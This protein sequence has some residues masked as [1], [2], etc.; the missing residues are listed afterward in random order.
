MRALVANVA[1]SYGNHDYG[2][3]LLLFLRI[4]LLDDKASR[5]ECI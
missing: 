1:Q 5:A 2:D 3:P 4:T